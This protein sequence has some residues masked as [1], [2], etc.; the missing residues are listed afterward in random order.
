MYHVYA[1]A[2]VLMNV[3]WLLLTLLGLPGNWLMLMGAGVLAWVYWDE[4]AIGV[5]TLIVLA[6]LALLGEVL[7]FVT[8]AAG[9]RKAGGSIW[10]AVLAIVGGIVGGVVGTFALPIPVVGT[11]IGACL[12]SAFFAVI[13]ELMVGRDL[14]TSLLTG[15][16]AFVGRLWGT[17]AKVV[18]GVVMWV[19]IAAAVYM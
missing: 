15:R 9:S 16:G 11:V 6:V 19:W 3:V 2:L 7:E 14:N 12:G 17:I 13:G 1:T 8:G 5:T 10:A 18:V 4:R